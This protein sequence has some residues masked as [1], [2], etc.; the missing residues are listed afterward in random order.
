MIFLILCILFLPHHRFNPALPVLLSLLP[1]LPFSYWLPPT[2]ILLVLLHLRPAASVCTPFPLPWIHNSSSLES[3]LISF[4]LLLF[5][6]SFLCTHWLPPPSL[7]SLLHPLPAP[8]S[9]ILY[10]PLPLLL[11][12]ILFIPP[13]WTFRPRPLPF[14]LE[15]P[16][17]SAS[18]FRLVILR[19]LLSSS[20]PSTSLSLSSYSLILATV[21][22]SSY[23]ILIFIPI[24]WTSSFCTPWHEHPSPNV[25]PHLSSSFYSASLCFSSSSSHLLFYL[26]SSS[27]L[28]S[29]RSLTVTLFLVR[30]YNVCPSI[31][32]LSPFYSSSLF[33]LLSILVF[34][35]FFF[36][37]IEASSSFFLMFNLQF[38]LLLLFLL[39][40]FVRLP[41]SF[42]API[43]VQP[44]FEP[45][46]PTSLL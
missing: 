13:S 33:H 32:L 31:Y 2:S 38:L 16:P 8:S 28:L 10:V 39:S 45:Q 9:C 21:A 3:S 34:L 42:P 29:S 14:P 25:D 6:H 12:H 43:S 37:D 20:S 19:Y 41:V 27:Y 30:L 40:P 7:I 17:F 35:L 23:L 36:L 11:F 1:I 26:F 22:T 46:I 24:S 5:P 4:R 15:E 18:S 44:L